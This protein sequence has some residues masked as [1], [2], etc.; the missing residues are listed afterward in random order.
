MVGDQCVNRAIGQGSRQRIAVALLAQRWREAGAAVK[1]A[2]VVFGQQQRVDGDVS[3]HVQA[4]GLGAAHQLHTR[5]AGQAAQVNAGFC[6]AN[7]LK[8]RVQRNGFGRHWHARETHARCQRTAGGNALAQVLVLWAQPHGIVKGAGVGHG[9]LQ[10]LNAGQWHI[11]LTKGDAAGFGQLGHF[12]QRLALEA[13]SQRTHGEQAGFVLLFGAELEHFH[14]TLLV[15][16]GVGVRQA[17]QAGDA[18]GHGRSHFRL[19]H[20]FVLMAGLAQAHG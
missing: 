7:Q 6:T 16:H 14:Q 9:A 8:N 1:V 10:R 15:E 17:D 18:P 12:G 2:D 4:F 13:D 5:S 19:Q 11:G 3:R 20:A